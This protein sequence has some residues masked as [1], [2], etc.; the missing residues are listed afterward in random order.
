M[1]GIQSHPFQIFEVMNLLYIKKVATDSEPEV[2]YR[3]FKEVFKT[4]N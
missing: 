3:I 4:K 2:I 1:N